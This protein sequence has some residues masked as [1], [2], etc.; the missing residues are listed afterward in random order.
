MSTMAFTMLGEIAEYET[1]MRFSAPCSV[2]TG[3]PC[4]S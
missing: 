4:R 2:A 1:L 3:F